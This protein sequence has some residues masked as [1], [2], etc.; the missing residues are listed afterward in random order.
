MLLDS[1]IML[2]VYIGQALCKQN[3]SNPCRPVP[4]F[5]RF[6]PENAKTENFLSIAL[7]MLS[8]FGSSIHRAFKDFGS[9]L[10]LFFFSLEYGLYEMA[11][12]NSCHSDKMWVPACVVR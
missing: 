10:A 3:Y 7:N 2:S 8:K 11:L 6:E 5:R 4:T 12:F 1:E 9:A